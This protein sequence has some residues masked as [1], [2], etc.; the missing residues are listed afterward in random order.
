MLPFKFELG[1]HVKDKVSGFNGVVVSRADHITQCNSY[2]V[3]P[4]EITKDGKKP[5]WE[6][7]DEPR[8]EVGN[9]KKDIELVQ[10]EYKKTG[11]PRSRDE[12]PQHN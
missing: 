12:F 1:Q 8:L 4:T 6:W 9:K 10:K 2:G 11:G 7:F 3:S 5:E